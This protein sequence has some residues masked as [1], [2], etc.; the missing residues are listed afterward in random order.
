MF[1]DSFR[2]CIARRSGQR[3]WG[4]IAGSGVAL[5]CSSIALQRVRALSA[6]D[7]LSCISALS[8]SRSGSR[9][10]CAHQR[11]CSGYAYAQSHGNQWSHFLL[12]RVLLQRWCASGPGSLGLLGW[13]ARVRASWA[14]GRG[15]RGR[16]LCG[17]S[18][19]AGGELW[20]WVQG[21]CVVFSMRVACTEARAGGRV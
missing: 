15:V 2:E 12:E 1:F 14:R 6:R 10:I 9:D 4:C 19:G 17:D 5:Q 8:S 16:W 18:G 20:L 21:G 11:V 3:Q 7:G 13:G